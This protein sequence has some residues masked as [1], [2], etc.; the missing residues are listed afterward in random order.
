MYPHRHSHKKSVPCAAS[1]ITFGP[2]SLLY[3]LSEA[4]VRV[5]SEALMCSPSEA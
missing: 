3:V 1:G 4:P 2:E 5:L